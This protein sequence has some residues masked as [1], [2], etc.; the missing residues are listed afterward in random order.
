[1]KFKTLVILSFPNTSF[2]YILKYI[3]LDT[4]GDFKPNFGIYASMLKITFKIMIIVS[5]DIVDF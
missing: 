5:I 4:V 2:S 1:L 3:D